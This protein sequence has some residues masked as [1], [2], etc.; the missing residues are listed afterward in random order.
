MRSSVGSYAELGTAEQPAG[1]GGI[2]AAA[3]PPVVLCSGAAGGVGGAK[4]LSESWKQLGTNLSVLAGDLTWTTENERLLQ[5]D[6]RDFCALGL[7]V[8]DLIDSFVQ[9]VLAVT[10]ID[11]QAARLLNAAGQF[12]PQK[13]QAVN[14]DPSLLKEMFCQPEIT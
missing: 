13:F 9:S 4:A 6:V 1:E 8:D 2:P 5:M 11:E 12:C 7:G 3:I 10:A 14:D